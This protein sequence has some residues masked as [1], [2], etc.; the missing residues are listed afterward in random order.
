MVA[1]KSGFHLLNFIT[2][3]L[4]PLA[5]PEATN[6]EVRFNDGKVS[7]D[8][9]FFAGT[10][11]ES[12]SRPIGCLYRLDPDGSCHRVANGLIVSNG[13]AWSGDGRLLFHSDSKGQLIYAWDYDPHSGALANRRVV[14]RP[15]EAVGRPDGGAF[16]QAACLQRHAGAQAQCF[17]RH[18]SDIAGS[19]SFSGHG[20]DVL[21][22][23]KT[24][25]YPCLGALLFWLTWYTAAA[26]VPALFWA[27]WLQ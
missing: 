11:D 1:L 26:N 9:R 23:H 13:L 3:R 15:D 8:G 19:G 2:G 17:Q 18:A 27:V 16:D 12:L 5:Q 10:M 25:S 22:G 24:W 14:A 20:V 21:M 7:P 4:L 6:P